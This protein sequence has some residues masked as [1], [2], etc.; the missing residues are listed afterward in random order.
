MKEMRLFVGN[1]VS[2]QQVEVDKLLT[3]H[4]RQNTI[5]PRPRGERVF[6]I[7]SNMRIS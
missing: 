2:V 6:W 4:H 7:L 5:I 3:Q 1:S